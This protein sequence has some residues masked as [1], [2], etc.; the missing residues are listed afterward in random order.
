MHTGNQFAI[1]ITQFDV[2]S[3]CN[4]ANIDAPFNPVANLRST[5][6]QN[7]FQENLEICI[8]AKHSNCQSLY[9]RSNLFEVD[10]FRE[11]DVQLTTF[12]T[13]APFE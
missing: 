3:G 6:I 5:C 1:H 11:N 10:L 8:T 2:C 4:S 12:K 7:R 13:E 9:L